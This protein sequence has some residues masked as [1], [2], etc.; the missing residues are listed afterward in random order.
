MTPSRGPKVLCM[1]LFLGKLLPQKNFAR[2][3]PG[4]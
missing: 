4:K 1:G 2:G 3:C